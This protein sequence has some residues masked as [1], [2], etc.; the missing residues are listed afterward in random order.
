MTLGK[1]LTRCL[2]VMLLSGPLYELEP[3]T[4]PEDRYHPLK[5]IIDVST[6]LNLKVY[7]LMSTG[8]LYSPVITLIILYRYSITFCTMILV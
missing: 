8:I 4:S 2:R 3:I 6:T 5:M 1:Y 7:Y